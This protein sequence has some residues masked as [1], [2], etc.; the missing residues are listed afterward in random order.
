MKTHF[1]STGTPRITDF[2][3]DLRRWLYDVGQRGIPKFGETGYRLRQLRKSLVQYWQTHDE[4][5]LENPEWKSESVELLSKLDC[6]IEQLER[7][8]PPFR[9]WQEL[10]QVLSEFGDELETFERGWHSI[11]CTGRTVGL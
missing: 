6:W 10:V 4:G 7:P 5:L 8:D 1:T 2:V 9:S 3:D 11:T